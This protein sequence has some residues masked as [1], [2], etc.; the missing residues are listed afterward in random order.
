MS[1][2]PS[3]SHTR[4]TIEQAL[5]VGRLGVW[6]VVCIVMAAAAPLTVI[7]GGATTGWAV[8]GVVG[9]PIGY[10]LVAL[11][12]AVFSVGYVAM[13]RQV[14]NS[15]A[16]YTYVTHGLGRVPGVGASAVAVLAYNAMQIGLYGGF[17]KVSADFVAAHLGWSV[18]WWLC[19]LA[20]WAVVALLGV[21][22]VDLNG[23]VLA[24]LL[25][26]EIG[27]ALVLAAVHVTHPAGGRVDLTAISPAQLLTS[28][29]GAVLVT[30][31]TGFVG[32]E[33]TAVFSEE[34]K[35]PRRTVARATYIA[36]AVIGV[37][38]SL[39]ALAMTVAVGPG[40][41][42]A[43]ATE[44]G[45]ELIFDLAA[46]YVPS[47]LLIAGHLLFITSLF[48]A[49][50]SFH[51][52]AARYFFALG[53]EGVLPRAL[54]RTSVRSRSPHVASITQTV[55]ACVVL[56]L[57]AYA[58]WD[59]MIN[60]FFWITVTGGLGVLV[61]MLVTSVAVAGYFLRPAN[62]VTVGAVRGL[63]APAL[64]AAA[65]GAILVITLQQFHVLLGVDPSSPWRWIF[66]A[67]FA[68]TAVLGMLWALYLRTARPA[69]YAAIG[70]GAH[71]TAI[72]ATDARDRR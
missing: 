70:A 39:C 23:R 72:D 59:P 50:L 12:L 68:A 4:T 29:I 15:G 51:N 69:V 31:I 53:R 8:T 14:V 58:G 5:A 64:A 25:I 45:T 36:L 63:L 7:A 21:R 24:T 33:G 32:F 57:Y 44:H 62:R 42:V 52:T 40:D 47:S 41:I 61:L 60:L 30:A 46:P 16:F 37:L 1:H 19:A 35:D 18:P 54:A 2:H 55:L 13:S 56:A 71:Q 43:A 48:A 66:P 27:V 11:V 65:L 38:Y 49:L 34:S 3:P 6:P 17:G 22:R 10:L 26:G 9:I 28:G 20:G 67:A